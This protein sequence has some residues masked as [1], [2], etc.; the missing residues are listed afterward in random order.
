MADERNLRLID[1]VRDAAAIAEMWNESDLEWPG[2]W[3][4]G[5]PMTA[6]YVRDWHE[7]EEHIAVFVWDEEERI[8]GY[9]S[10][11]YDKDDEALYLEL[12]NVS[13][14][15]QGRSIGRRML[16]RSVEKTIEEKK[17]RLD[18]D[19]WPGN[20]KA[21][22]PYKR[23]GFFWDAGPFTLMRNYI[24]AIRQ[25]PSTQSFFDRHDWYGTLRRSVEQVPDE[26]KWEG[27]GVFTY[28]FEARGD[29]QSSDGGGLTDGNDF[30]TVR[31]DRE[32]RHVTAVETT[33]LSAAATVDEIE[34]VRGR[35]TTLRWKLHNRKDSPITLSL[36]AR[37]SGDLAID[38]HAQQQVRP[39]ETITLEAPVVV[40]GKA[41]AVDRGKTAPRVYTHIRWDDLPIVLATGIRP[42]VEMSVS[43]DPD[44]ITLVPGTPQNVRVN[45]RSHLPDDVEAQVRI[46]VSGGLSVDRRE[47]TVR[48]PAGGY[49]GCETVLEADRPDV[50][51]LTL[52]GR[53]EWDGRTVDL[54]N[55]RHAVFALEPGGLLY[56]QDGAIRVENE[57]YRASL[58][59]E[60]GQLKIRDRSTGKD[61][62]TEG[63]RPIP[64]KWPSEFSESDFKL[65]AKWEGHDLVLVACYAAGKTPG[66][67][68][69]RII[70]LNA[71]PIVSVEHTVENTGFDPI[72]F[73]LYQ[74]VTNGATEH[75][76]LTLPLKEGMLRARCSDRPA[77]DDHDFKRGDSFAETW[78]AFEMAHG[79]VGVF[80]PGDLDEIEWNGYEF[81]SVSREMTCA[82]QSRV[83]FGAL[84]LFIGDGGWQG[85]RRVWRR[86]KGQQVKE[87][88]PA[89][90]VL[91]EF[92]VSTD[93]PLAVVTREET[94]IRFRI[95]QWKSRKAGGTVT[96][97]MPDGWL[98]DPMWFS[99]SE[100]DWQHPFSGSVRLTTSRP[101]GVY[102][103]R[104][105]LEGGERDVEVEMP[106]VRLGDGSAVEVEVGET[107]EHRVYTI[108]NHR[109][110][111]DVVPSFLG[112]VSA[113]RD[114]EGGCNHLA[115]AFPKP[116][117]LGWSY[118]WYGGLQ[119]QVEVDR[120]SWTA[121]LEGEKFTAETVSCS[122]ARGM[123]GM[124][125]TGVRQRA[126]L[127]LEETRGLILELDTLTL[128]GSPVIKQVWR[129]VNGG[130]TIRRLSGGWNYL[131]QP[132]GEMQDTVL[133]SADYERKRSDWDYRH[134]GGHWT[135]AAN[136]RT[137][138]TFVLVSPLKEA[139]L[140][141][142]GTGGGHL[143]L[144]TKLEVPAHG[145]KEMTAYLVLADS[146]EEGRK[147][148][149]LKDLR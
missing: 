48:V 92:A 86:T 124:E 31:V 59:T 82:P 37:E 143:I 33:E 88:E 49:G 80:W 122:D 72:K 42:R 60:G 128:G 110:E 109:L 28:R 105:E 10:L 147:Y 4:A 146:R 84:R 24:P 85:A 113:I 52:T 47:H 145:A 96:F 5:V 140:D 15:Y 127:S 130:D 18:L 121:S 16:V 95:A 83:T 26:E 8:G 99:F 45:L 22:A 98:C 35:Q 91:D 136:P 76:T 129:V 132:D 32:A 14:K 120:L 38:Y 65:S 1:P 41:A 93:P 19:T 34:P 112:S 97:V 27:M 43:I 25:M 71:G 114:A 149:V 73:N 106:L 89:P 94:D 125:W 90:P 103:G 61:L 3:N 44:E 74:F 2:S 107:A 101:P 138:R 142:W 119:P 51:E 63:A 79:T 139:R 7:R 29:Q 133:F 23:T 104:M 141:S 137:G 87:G 53:L 117:A 58:L 77:P 54:S 21:M 40:S 135:A 134:H 70:R 55:A 148:T 100:I 30:L 81:Q 64:P 118:P 68:F 12:L 78:G 108:R 57:I 69:S 116:R 17:P 9:C 67:V 20:V 13:P 62:G 46:N 115:S 56:H 131:L 11:V 126:A 39:G 144:K 66:L 50:F 36:S 75:S 111:I 102:N 123:G 6:R